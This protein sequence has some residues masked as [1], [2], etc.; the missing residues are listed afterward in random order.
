VENVYSA[1]KRL[2]WSWRWRLKRRDLINEEKEMRPC[3]SDM[4]WSR[5]VEI[6]V[7]E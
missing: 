5:D 1:V 4:E 7:G 3:E 2:E 6:G